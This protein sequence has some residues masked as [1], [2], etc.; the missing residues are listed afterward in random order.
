MLEVTAELLWRTPIEGAMWGTSTSLP[1]WGL[2]NLSSKGLWR[3]KEG[4]IIEKV[5]VDP[6]KSG[7]EGTH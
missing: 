1:Y 7:L 5:E 2:L 6:H 3:V 4:M